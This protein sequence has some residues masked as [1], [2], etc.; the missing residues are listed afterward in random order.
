MLLVGT[1]DSA[2][3]RATRV[4][5][6]FLMMSVHLVPG[7]SGVSFVTHGPGAPIGDV[8]LGY[9]GRASVATLSLVSGFLVA[10]SF[11]KHDLRRIMRDRG[12]A[13]L[14]PMM[15]WNLV[16]LV[17]ILLGMLAGLRFAEVDP[18]S[19]ATPFGLLNAVTGLFGPSV[20]LSLFFLRDLFAATVLLALFWPLLHRHLGLAL[21]V[22]LLLTV[23]DLT[24]P[25]IFRPSILL[26][27]LAGCA[28]RARGHR[29][30]D[31]A[32][33]RL[34]VPGLLTAGLVLGLCLLLRGGGPGPLSE[35]QNIAKRAALVFAVLVLA[36]A[37]GRRPGLQAFLDRF[38]PVAFLSYL[39]HV[40]LAKLLWLAAGAAGITLNGPSYLIYF[41]GAP[42]LVFGLALLAQPAVDA[43]PGPLPLLI[44]GKAAAG[45]GRPATVIKVIPG[46]AD[47]IPGE[48]AGGGAQSPLHGGARGG[49]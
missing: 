8:W 7:P 11:G 39:S 45:P 34:A 3:I 27:M 49:Q 1:A 30:S 25:V 32:A 29:L 20:N 24:A 16:G 28:L 17:A 48:A 26:F 36:F 18:A 4:I 38:E 35:L 46:H 33:P 47:A 6:I 42:M 10:G 44:K 21:A 41:F 2:A 14:V 22:V 13:I 37:I 9:F 23:F 12:R 5:C 19:F 43:L 40:L 15:G 31:L